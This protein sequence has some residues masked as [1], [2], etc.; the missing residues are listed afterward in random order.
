VSFGLHEIAWHWFAD[1]ATLF[2]NHAHGPIDNR[3]AG[4]QPAP[5][6]KHAAY[7]EKIAPG[8]RGSVESQPAVEPSETEG[9]H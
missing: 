3:S 2:C 7:R 1:E 8:G 4:W 6:R 9:K 5:R